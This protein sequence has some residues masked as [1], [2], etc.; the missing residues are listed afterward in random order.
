MKN[1]FKTLLLVIG[2]FA[3]TL[4]IANDLQTADILYEKGKIRE[5]LE[6]YLKPEN[7]DKTAVQFRIWNIYLNLPDS[8]RSV[9]W[10]SQSAK[11][12]NV[13]AQYHLGLIYTNGI[14]VKQD[15]NKALTLFTQTAE[16]GYPPALNSMG[17][18]YEEGSG[19]K[20]SDY[21][22]AQWYL[23][24]AKKNYARS[25]CN[26]AGILTYSK[27]IDKNYHNAY[28]LL[29]TCLR[30]KPDNECCLNRMAELYS[31]GWGVK[32]DNK[33]AIE[34]REKAATVGSEVAMY[35]LGVYYDYGIGVKKDGQTA[36]DWYLKASAKNHAKAMYRLYE[37]YEYGKLGQTVDKATAAE[38]KAKA[39]K[40]MKEQGLSRN[41][42]RDRFR[43]LMEAGEN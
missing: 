15:Y 8:E 26:L 27:T 20:Q 1:L 29:Q 31:N 25:Q 10:F 38:W 17:I 18:L 6:I 12:G 43:L 42:L 23:K 40:A 3:A 2:G 5:A 36:I 22:A 32:M 41:E 28:L 21:E 19:V 9:E 4:S 33:K 11:E 16:R 34:L 7:R 30:L 14:G 39:E 24:A 35:N 13:Y 37:A